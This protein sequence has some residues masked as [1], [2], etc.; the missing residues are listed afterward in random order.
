MTPVLPQ[1]REPPIED[2]D[3]RAHVAR[4]ENAYVQQ[5]LDALY[6]ERD[7]LTRQLQSIVR[8]DYTDDGRRAMQTVRRVLVVVA[9]ATATVLVF[10]LGRL[11]G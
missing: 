10:V 6:E 2:A 9:V 5:Y 11:S 7:D 1:R 8:Q 3:L 4:H